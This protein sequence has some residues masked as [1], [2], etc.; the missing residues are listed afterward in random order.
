[1]QH[2]RV[3]RKIRK[4]TEHEH[5]A[6]SVSTHK[7]TIDLKKQK[8]Q[9]RIPNHNTQIDHKVSIICGRLEYVYSDSW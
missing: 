6:K 8:A 1:M 5:T 9:Q 2:I 4:E 7:E 3:I